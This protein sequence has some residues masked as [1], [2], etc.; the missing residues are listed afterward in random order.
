[1]RKIKKNSNLNVTVFDKFSCQ[2]KHRKENEILQTISFII[3]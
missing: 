3:F 2:K 1:M